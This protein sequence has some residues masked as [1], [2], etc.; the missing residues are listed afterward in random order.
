[1]S[2]FELVVAAVLGANTNAL[3][4]RSCV[5]FRTQPACVYAEQMAEETKNVLLQAQVSLN[6]GSW[7]QNEIQHWIIAP[8]GKNGTRG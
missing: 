7:T 2:G 6:S 5:Q 8:I 3:V 1:M 4:I